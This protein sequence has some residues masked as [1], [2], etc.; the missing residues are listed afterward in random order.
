MASRKTLS[1]PESGL[2][3]ESTEDNDVNMTEREL[4]E[5]AASGTNIVPENAGLML[6]N[7][8]DWARG[9]R[10]RIRAYRHV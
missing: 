9:S 7:T 5:T 10:W 3:G 2:I 8:E 1:E 6:T 4:V